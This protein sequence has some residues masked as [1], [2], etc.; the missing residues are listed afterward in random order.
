MLAEPEESHREKLVPGLKP[1]FGQA[2]IATFGKVLLV[3]LQALQDTIIGCRYRAAKPFCIY[4]T[5]SLIPVGFFPTHQPLLHD[6]LTGRIQSRETLHHT[7]AAIFSGKEIWTGLLDLRVTFHFR[8][9]PGTTVTRN[10]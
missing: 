6:L 2:L 9:F 1:P 5:R 4:N 10:G 7:T 8:D 3:L